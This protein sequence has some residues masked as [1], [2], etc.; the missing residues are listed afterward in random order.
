MTPYYF[1][2]KLLETWKALNEA[3]YTL[4]DLFSYPIKSTEMITK[5]AA[6]G[7]L[8]EPKGKRSFNKGFVSSSSKLWNTTPVGL[9]EAKTR[10]SARKQ[11]RDLVKKLPT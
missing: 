5:A 2:Y 10:S 8:H 9:R 3:P 1:L 7:D 4:K 11:V 6:R